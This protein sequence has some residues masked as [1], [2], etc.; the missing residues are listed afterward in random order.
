MSLRSSERPLYNKQCNMRYKSYCLFNKV[1]YNNKLLINNHAFIAL[2]KS[3][4][5]KLEYC[6]S[7]EITWKAII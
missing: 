6:L 4:I 5:A 1:F 3:I 7:L 2:C